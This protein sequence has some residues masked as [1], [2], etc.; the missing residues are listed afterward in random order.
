[1]ALA[2]LASHRERLAIA[3]GAQHGAACISSSPLDEVARHH[4]IAWASRGSASRVVD[5]AGGR[6]S[7]IVATFARAWKAAASAAA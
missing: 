4:P 3:D 6:H 2:A 7:A 1:V 5:C